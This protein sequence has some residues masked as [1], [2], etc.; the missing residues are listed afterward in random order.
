MGSIQPCKLLGRGVRCKFLLK[1]TAT[2][3]KQT[4]KQTILCSV[5]MTA[6]V[7]LKHGKVIADY[8]EEMKDRSIIF[9]KNRMNM[10]HILEKRN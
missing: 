6:A 2:E 1:I 8:Y 9:E 5:K 10:E 4:N 7:Q 3:I